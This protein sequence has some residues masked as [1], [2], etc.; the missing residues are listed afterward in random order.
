VEAAARIC[1]GEGLELC[2][3]RT[4]LQHDRGVISMALW[5]SMAQMAA[6]LCLFPL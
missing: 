1:R 6:W 5:A 2:T 3:W 4:C